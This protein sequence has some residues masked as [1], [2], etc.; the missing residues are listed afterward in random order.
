M[1]R[2]FYFSFVLLVTI[3]VGC[4]K[5]VQTGE[6]SNLEAT[7]AD[8]SVR[9]KSEK[10]GYISFNQYDVLLGE[11]EEEFFNTREFI[12]KVNNERKHKCEVLP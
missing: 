1:K 6:V 9:I 7:T 12:K 2:L 4:S 8:I 11:S 10:G 5:M 3:L